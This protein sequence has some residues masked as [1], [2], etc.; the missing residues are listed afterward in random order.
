[1]ASDND[2]YNAFMTWYDSVAM[3]NNLNLRMAFD[4]GWEACEKELEQ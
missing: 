1:M 3:S 4:A 2:T